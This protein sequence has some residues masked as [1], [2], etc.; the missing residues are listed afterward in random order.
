MAGAQCHTWPAANNSSRPHRTSCNVSE[1]I[2]LAAVI[3]LLVAINYGFSNHIQHIA[4][5]HMDARSGTIVNVASTAAMM[6]L[7]APLYLDTASLTSPYVIYFA[8]AGLIV[9]SLSMTFH[10]LGVKMIGP[11]LT[12]GLASTSPVFAMTAAVILLGEVVDGRILAGTAIVIAG[13]MAIALRSRRIGVSWPL[14]A[15]SLPILAALSRG[16]SHPLIKLGLAGIPSPLMAALVSS[17]V[18]FMV[19]FVASRYSGHTMPRWSRGYPWFVACGVMNGIGLTGIA[20]A[21]DVGEVIVV[22]PLISTTPA[23]TLLLGFLIFKRETISWW[24]VAAIGLI[25]IG[26]VLIITR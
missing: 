11:G 16:I 15:I 20:I 6:W 10:T 25:F 21:L 18:S 26:C 3:S 2:Y 17:T 1:P 24:S 22:A 5:D 13:V 4:L 8:A 19:L 23:F 7:L 9:P 14:W 12:A